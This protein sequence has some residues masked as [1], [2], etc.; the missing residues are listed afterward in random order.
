MY[1]IHIYI[2]IYQQCIVSPNKNRWVIPHRPGLVQRSAT[3]LSIHGGA[4]LSVKRVGSGGLVPSNC[5]V[6]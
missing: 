5:D 2:C 3:A 4:I 1:C 6:I